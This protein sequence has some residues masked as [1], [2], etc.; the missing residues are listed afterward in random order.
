MKKNLFLCL[1]IALAAFCSCSD[2][3]SWAPAYITDFAELHTDGSGQVVKMIVDT[4]AAN[5]SFAA[6]GEQN[7][8]SQ[9]GR[10]LYI[11]NA[12]TVTAALKAVADTVYRCVCVYTVAE[13]GCATIHSVAETFS[14]QPVE[15]TDELQM[16]TDPCEIQSIW[17]SRAYT[18][19][20]SRPSS[21]W[22]NARMLVQGKDL[23]H[24]VDY[25]D[26]GIVLNP[27]TGVNTLTLLLYHDRN[28]DIEAFTRTIYLS[29]P[30]KNYADR[31][32]PGRD[33][34]HFVVN[35]YEKGITTFKLA[36]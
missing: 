6:G 36:Y 35:Q 25:I 11:E 20:A 4:P 32:V 31:L 18:A 22:L 14:P 10:E 5:A 33:S 1:V 2:D 16:K 26:N 28:G 9:R 21:L 19:D 29:C 13:S 12:A 24:I 8:Y 23:P 7:S 30:L 15:A 3:D 27:A 17:L 34:I